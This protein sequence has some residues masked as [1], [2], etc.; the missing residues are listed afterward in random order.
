MLHLFNKVY[1]TFDNT[2]NIKDERIVISEGNGFHMMHELKQLYATDVFCY[3]QK[4]ESLI[5]TGKQFESFEI[6][7]ETIR[8][9]NL[10][11]D[12]PLVIYCDRN[13]YIKF[14]I[15]WYKTIFPNITF[16]SFYNY[17]K[18]SLFRDKIFSYWRTTTLSS[19]FRDDLPMISED[20]LRIEYSRVNTQY[21]KD[22]SSKIKPYLS[23][24]FMLSNFLY[25]GSFEKE[26]K[27]IISKMMTRHYQELII[28]VK[29]AIYKNIL[30]ENLQNFLGIEKYTIKNIEDFLKNDKLKILI[31]S[32]LVSTEILTLIGK[33]S[34]INFNLA[35]EKEIVEIKN[36]LKSFFINWE[37]I[38]EN[39]FLIQRINLLDLVTKNE[40]TK[41]DLTTVLNLE[42]NSQDSIR[43]FSSQD[44]EKINFFFI[45]YIFDCIKTNKK[46]ELKF[47]V[48]D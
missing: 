38:S 18:T 6:F 42:I 23:M 28:E 43:F 4:L 12:K 48:L 5:G 25:N 15:L 36:I 32:N 16:D 10:R 17:I 45:D 11:E 33:E 7:L 3:S 35:T 47:Y 20:E 19:L 22:F 44:E 37:K 9:K 34:N 30:K 13:N 26:L 40:L 14:I 1:L 46:E 39:S 24:E 29:Q 2:I 31:N 41:E 21:S 27:E 8:E